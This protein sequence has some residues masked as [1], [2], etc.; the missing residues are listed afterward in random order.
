MPPDRDFFISTKS[1]QQYFNSKIK[2]KDIRE[3]RKPQSDSEKA[4]IVS[5][6]FLGLSNSK[7]IDLFFIRRRH[8]KLDFYYLS[9]SYFDV[10]KRTLRDFNNK[11]LLPN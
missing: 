1:P 8:D 9:Q 4:I 7:S 6:D 5:D 3:K 2:I 10:P 11:K